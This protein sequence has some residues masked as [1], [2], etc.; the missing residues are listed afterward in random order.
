MKFE[1]EIITKC[2]IKVGQK[3]YG[4]IECSTR[5][6]DGIYEII[7]DEIDYDGYRV[8]FKIEQPCQYVQCSFYNMDKY[9][10]ETKEKAENE[11]NSDNFNFGEGL[12][13]Y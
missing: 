12:Y 10:F 7:V 6:Y 3:L 8:I 2:N 11:Y 5:T 9:V 4:I 13:E 1:Y